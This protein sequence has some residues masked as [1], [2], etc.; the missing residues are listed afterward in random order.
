MFKAIY[1]VAE[2]QVREIGGERDEP[3]G[4]RFVDGTLNLQAYVMEVRK[5]AEE[6]RPRHRKLLGNM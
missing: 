5:D 1:Q 2:L 6:T 3:T 4:K